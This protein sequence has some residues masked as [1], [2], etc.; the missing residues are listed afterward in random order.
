MTAITVSTLFL[1]FIRLSSGLH[2]NVVQTPCLGE[3]ILTYSQRADF[4]H[5]SV[6]G[7]GSG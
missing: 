2:I 3:S 7:L 4:L 6:Y 1:V 5:F